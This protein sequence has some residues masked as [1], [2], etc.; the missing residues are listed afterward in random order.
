MHTGI[1]LLNFGEPETPSLED[2][3]PFL[4]AIFTTNMRLEHGDPGA[5]RR[6]A[7]ELAERR[8]PG[9]VAEYRAIGGSPLNART[10]DQAD[11]L[12]DAL[13][14]RGHG[15]A[16]SVGMQFTPPSIGDAVSELHDAGADGLI[17]VPLYPLCGPSTTV[18]AVTEMH[19]AARTL[20]PD[21]PVTG[22]AGWHTAAGYTELRADGVREFC[23]DAG[24]DL[25]DPGT[26]LVFSAHGTPVSYL[27][28]SRYDVYVEDHARRLGDALGRDYVIGYQN[29]AN[30]PGVEW[31]RPAVEDVIQEVDAARAVVVPV[32]F[33]Q[34]QSET[35]YELD[36]E[37]R[38]VAE[39]RGLGFHRVP[40]PDDDG[41][42]AGVLADVLMDVLDGGGDFQRCQCAGSD[43]AVCLNRTLE[44]PG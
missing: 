29:H 16:V 22:I 5:G 32:S 9:L 43:V 15:V 25:A 23:R 10:R 13:E 37:L 8:A 44:R 36:H 26:A 30:R 41:R 33:M 11:A 17:G 4:E 21:W 1:L 34:E 12:R 7:R 6:R 2:V 42:F 24:V 39:A 19:R 35:L 38:G 14:S 18:A 31:T 40:V 20:D 28:G 27:A 3:V